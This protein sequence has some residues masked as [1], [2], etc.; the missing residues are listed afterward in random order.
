MRHDS[1]LQSLRI[2]LVDAHTDTVLALSRLLSMEGHVVRSA[3]TAAQA[4]AMAPECDL[5]ICE[6]WLPE[7]DAIDMIR[8][9]KQS[10]DIPV[11]AFSSQ[12]YPRDIEAAEQAGVEQLIP[13]PCDPARIVAAVREV[14]ARQAPTDADITK[15][16]VVEDDP[17]ALY[18]LD[19]ALRHHGLETELAANYAQAVKALD[20]RPEWLVLDLVLGDRDARPIL[21]RIREEKLPIKVAVVTGIA[22][23]QLLDEC[24]KMDPEAWFTKPVDMPRLVSKLSA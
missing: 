9:L 8:E 16:L 11:I 18:S 1:H 2:L 17:A 12:V 19:R 14:A 24:A 10:R 7:G 5:M 4:L 21:R 22:D 20:H 3:S 23:Q 6:L 13:K 15:V